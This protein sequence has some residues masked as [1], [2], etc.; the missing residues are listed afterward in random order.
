[1]AIRVRHRGVG[2]CTSLDLPYGIL[3]VLRCVEFLARIFRKNNL[4]SLRLC[5]E[6]NNYFMAHTTYCAANRRSTFQLVF[7]EGNFFA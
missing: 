3:F 7:L 5:G 1:M 2:L 4:E 6:K